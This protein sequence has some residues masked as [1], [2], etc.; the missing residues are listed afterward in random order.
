ML[1]RGCSRAE[2]ALVGPE[3]W[4][5]LPYVRSHA[6]LPRVGIQAEISFAAFQSC[7]V[8]VSTKNLS[9]GHRDRSTI[10]HLAWCMFKVAR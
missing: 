3:R 5:R 6:D 9:L 4:V 10:S 1:F 7:G 8:T 2:L